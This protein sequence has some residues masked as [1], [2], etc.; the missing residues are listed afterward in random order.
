MHIEYFKIYKCLIIFKKWISNQ[1]RVSFALYNFKVLFQ[2]MIVK[3]PEH[4]CSKLYGVL[5]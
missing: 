1:F 3:I 5:V 4:T 2:W